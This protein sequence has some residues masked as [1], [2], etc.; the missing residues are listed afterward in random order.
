MPRQP[1][2]PEVTIQCC[3]PP[4]LWPSS[5]LDSSLSLAYLSNRPALTACAPTPKRVQRLRISV[6][7]FAVFL[8]HTVVI[9][10][11][12]WNFQYCALHPRPDLPGLI[13]LLLLVTSSRLV[14]DS[15]KDPAYGLGAYR[16]LPDT[17]V[18]VVFQHA[19]L[20]GAKDAVV[21]GML[22]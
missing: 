19:I 11:F 13:A 20:A 22:P 17:A 21:P 3:V 6:T 4:S 8:V 16:L 2:L 10:H 5:N 7:P 18:D 14:Y 12:N 15:R 9:I 1:T